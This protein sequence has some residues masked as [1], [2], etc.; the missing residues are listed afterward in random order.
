MK[1]IYMAV[2]CLCLMVASCSD[3]EFVGDSSRPTLNDGIVILKERDPSLPK[4]AKCP[5]IIV[6]DQRTRVYDETGG[7]IG[8]TDALLGYSYNVGNSILGDYSNVGFQVLDLNKVKADDP[9]N[10]LSKGLRHYT[11]EIFTYSDYDSYESHV[12]ETK[13]V[14]SGFSLNLVFFKIGRKKTTEN[15]FQSDLTSNENVVFGELSMRYDHSSFIL[16]LDPIKY[17]SRDCLSKSF[18]RNLYSTTI[19]N[20]LDNYGEYVLTGYITGGKAFSLFSG[21]DN[22][23]EEHSVKLSNLHKNIGLSFAWNKDSAKLGYGAGRGDST[24]TTTSYEIKSLYT[25]LWLYGGNPMGLGMSS[26]VDIKNVNIDLSPWLSSLSDVNTHTITDITSN[27]LCPLY[28]FL[29]EENFRTRMERTYLGQLLS[30]DKNILPFIEVIR[31]FE[32]YDDYGN[33]LY[34]IAAAL[35]TRQGDRI[36]LHT[37]D[38]SLKSDDE[39][40]S[41][42]DPSVFNQKAVEIKQEKEKYYGLEFRANSIEKLNPLIG[43]VLCIDLRK[44]DEPAMCRFTNPTTGIQYIYDKTRKIAFSYLIDDRDGDWILDE[45]G[46]R[47]WVESLPEKS[48][49]MATL[50]NSYKIIGL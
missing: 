2:A 37:E 16:N 45:Y 12:L 38:P 3:E 28:A 49:L 42:D 43:N 48:I 15:V 6:D 17:Y 40:R 7:L 31:V 32:R 11:N 34:D 46:I 13:K 18:E 47:D 1:N 19:G 4:E 5:P 35:H 20:M 14:N 27:G 8:N 44:V 25:K 29:L 50:A 36:I 33:A 41:Y 30:N 39:L 10:I 23:K 9:Q 21:I 26:A 24:S 22:S